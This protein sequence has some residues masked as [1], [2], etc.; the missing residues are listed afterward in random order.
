MFFQQLTKD[1]LGLQSVLTN[2]FHRLRQNAGAR[3]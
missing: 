1:I 2:F 3:A